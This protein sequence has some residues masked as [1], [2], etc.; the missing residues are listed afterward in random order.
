M[1]TRTG[2]Y[3]PIRGSTSTCADPQPPVSW[4]PLCQD[5]EGEAL[6]KGWLESRH[7]ATGP[8]ERAGEGAPEACGLGG[9]APGLL[10]V[11]RGLVPSCAFDVFSSGAV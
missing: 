2:T 7:L 1:R 4:H 3:L 11:C 10:G 5:A 8:V 9:Q 6:V